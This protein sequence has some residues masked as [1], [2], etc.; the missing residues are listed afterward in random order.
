[1]W[2]FG[3]DRWGYNSDIGSGIYSGDGDIYRYGDRE[4]ILE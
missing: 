2:D 3:K 4:G 1:V